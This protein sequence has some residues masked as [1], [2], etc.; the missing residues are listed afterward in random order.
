[1]KTEDINIIPSLTKGDIK[2]LRSDIVSSIGYYEEEILW[3]KENIVEFNKVI[4]SINDICFDD[5]DTK[6]IIISLITEEIKILDKAITLDESQIK[7]YQDIDDKLK[8]LREKP[9]CTNVQ[10][11]PKT[12]NTAKKKRTLPG[13]LFQSTL[14]KIPKK[15][16]TKACFDEKLSYR[17]CA[18]RF[19]ISE[20]TL[21]KVFKYYK[22]EYRP[23]PEAM[24]IVHEKNPEHGSAGQFKPKKESEPEE[25][26]STK[27]FQGAPM[28]STEKML[29]KILSGKADMTK[30][31]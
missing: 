26:I 5:R 21:H 18:K 23:I 9:K 20:N 31:H 16:L 2:I 28:G 22:L 3:R 10:V 15:E 24:K 25:V 1:M 27:T 17:D 30:I 12:K 4:K 14:D 19:S 8:Y 11:Q 13:G 7:T 6:P 29:K